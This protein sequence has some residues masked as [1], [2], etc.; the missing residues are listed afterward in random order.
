MRQRWCFAGPFVLMLGS[1]V[2]G[3][4]DASGRASGRRAAAGLER[5]QGRG[6]QRSALPANGEGS[7]RRERSISHGRRLFAEAHGQ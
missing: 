7:A 4:P 2:A 5:R 1:R 3:R 6:R